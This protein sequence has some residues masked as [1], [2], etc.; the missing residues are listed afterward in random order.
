LHNFL[1]KSLHFIFLSLD[2]L[3]FFSNGVSFTSISKKSRKTEKKFL[4]KIIPYEKL[5]IGVYF[6]QQ[7]VEING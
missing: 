5:L 2:P 4:P 7:N 6:G 1:K 3:E